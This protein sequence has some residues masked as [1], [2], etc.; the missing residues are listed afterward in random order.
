[1]KASVVISYYLGNLFAKALGVWNGKIEKRVSLTT[2]LLLQIKSIKLIGLQ[3]AAFNQIQNLR[4]VEIASFKAVR[5]ITCVTVIIGTWR[6][7]YILDLTT[8]QFHININYQTSDF[9]I[10]RVP[11]TRYCWWPLLDYV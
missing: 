9:D 1:V 2:K 8:I 7:P 3:G 10:Y 11:C 4:L 5:W 6:R